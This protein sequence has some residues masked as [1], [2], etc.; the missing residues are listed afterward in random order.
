MRLALA[1]VLVAVCGAAH[2]APVIVCSTGDA[3]AATSGCGPAINSAAS[4]NLSADGNWYVASNASG[5]F[6]SQAFVTINNVAPLQA[7]GPWLANNTNDIHGVG[8][9]SSWIILTS[10]QG[11][12]FPNGH[13]Y[14]STQFV[15][16]AETDLA[17]FAISGDWLADDYGLG[18]FLNGTAIS[19]ANLPVFGGEGGAMV[20]FA[21]TSGQFVVGPNTL[22]FEVQNDST[23]HGAL[24]DT[25]TGSPFGV[26][27]LITAAGVT[28][29]TGG[30]PEPT[31]WALLLVGF[32]LAGSGLRA[33][34]RAIPVA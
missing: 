18:I 32:G 4:N 17:H 13:S 27:V 22:T 20:P 7:P 24:T 1:V 3:T 5:A 6:F 21:V 12:L 25:H 8:A 33:R 15:L 10:D 31:T 29:P 11:N 30:V 26:R 23:D 16:G 28:S 2:A 14:F 9:G 34:R 19:Q